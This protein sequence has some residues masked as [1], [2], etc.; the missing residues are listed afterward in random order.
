MTT[1]SKNLPAGTPLHAGTLVRFTNLAGKRVVGVVGAGHP[2]GYAYAGAQRMIEE[3]EEPSTA[4]ERMTV[5]QSL[6]PLIA[7]RWGVPVKTYP[8]VRI[9]DVEIIEDPELLREWAS[10]IE[11]VVAA[12]SPRDGSPAAIVHDDAGNLARA[13]L[14][15]AQIRTHI[16][17]GDSQHPAMPGLVR[18]IDELVGTW[19]PHPDP[20]LEPHR[21]PIWPEA[22]VVASGYEA[23]RR[24]S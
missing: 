22:L 15:A 9:R 11:A 4:H 13:L 2:S 23:R 10:A 1:T 17:A 16:D 7:I 20:E 24:A 5:P 3:R 21:R 19:M 14:V 8:F 12:H 6:W 18:D